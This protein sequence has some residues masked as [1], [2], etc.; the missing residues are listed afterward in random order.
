MKRLLSAALAL[1]LL[2]GTAAMADPFGPG[3]GHQDRFDR[4]GG[5]HYRHHDDGTGAAVAVGFGLLALTAILA[6][7]DRDQARERDYG[8][9]P[10]PPPPPP[11]GPNYGPNDRGQG[12]DHSQGYGPDNSQGYDNNQNDGPGNQ[13]PY[14]N[15]RPDGRDR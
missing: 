15:N 7:S 5:R 14:D 13:G 4:D 11:N 12:Y 9:P 8:N 1:S 6:A 3:P 10:P 2:S